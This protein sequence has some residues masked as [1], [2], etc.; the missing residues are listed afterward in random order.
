[1]IWYSTDDDHVDDEHADIIDD[2]AELEQNPA[3]IAESVVHEASVRVGFAGSAEP[4][5]H[6]DGGFG[7]ESHEDYHENTGN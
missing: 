2:N 5:E 1:M 4:E 7:Q 6:L 3:N